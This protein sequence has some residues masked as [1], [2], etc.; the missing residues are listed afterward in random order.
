MLGKAPNA[1]ELAVAR[2]CGDQLFGFEQ[3]GGAAR[4]PIESPRRGQ[5]PDLWT[6]DDPITQRVVPA[7]S[8]APLWVGPP[9]GPFDGLGKRRQP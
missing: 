9:R 1:D 7:K 5:D 2:M 4:E 6:D 8:R 3:L